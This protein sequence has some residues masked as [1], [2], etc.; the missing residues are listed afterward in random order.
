[1]TRPPSRPDIGRDLEA[2]AEAARPHWRRP[3]FQLAMRADDEHGAA[4]YT[5]RVNAQ[6]LRRIV[7]VFGWPGRSL[8][9]EAGCRAAVEI[10]LHVDHDPPF[11]R[12]LLRMLQ[13]AVQRGQA[14]PA[15]W[16]RLLDRCLVREAKPQVYGTQHWYRPDGRL[17]P[18][19][20]DDPVSLTARRA[21]IGLPPY[22][23]SIERL[24]RRHTA[25]TRRPLS[26]PDSELLVEWSTA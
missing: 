6:A 26:G 18:H 21:Q 5:S 23:A 10:A 16:A 7:S 9:G 15:Q 20:I 8:V 19:P 13:E 17:V 14:T 24:R 11:Q 3:A 1:M 4:D 2:R 25:P 22:S 12:T